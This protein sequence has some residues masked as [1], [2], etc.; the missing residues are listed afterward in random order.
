MIGKISQ[1]K[2]FR[3]A[4]DYILKKDAEILGGSMAGRS[5]R[6]LATEF[7]ITRKLREDIGAPCY[8][9][10][11][12]LPAGERLSS[13]EWE[14]VAAK[15]LTR[16]GLDPQSHQHVIVRHRD[17]NFDHA[18]IVVSRIALD[19]N[20]WKPYQ[21]RFKSKNICR[22][23]EKE[24]NL[25]VVSN[26]KKNFRAQTTQKERRMAQ[27]TGRTPEKVQVQEILST[28]LSKEN[29]ISYKN[30]IKALEQHSVIAVPNVA[31]TGK[32]SGFSFQYAGR[33]LTGSQ[34]GYSW[35]HLQP[36]LLPP[37][38]EEV[39]WLQ[40]RKTLL[41]QGTP[42]DA[43][44]SLRNACWE[45]GARGVNF[46]TAL[47][48]QGWVLEN[49]TLKK[50]E[51]RYPLSAFVDPET[52]QKAL[53]TLAAVSREK[54][55]AAAER[56]REITRGR[57]FQPR[58]SF[59]R[60]MGSEDLLLTM[61]LFPQVA[62]FLIA[63]TAVAEIARSVRQ[64]VAEQALRA[65]MQAAWR[66]ANTEVRAEIKKMQEGIRYGRDY[67]SDKTDIRKPFADGR[68]VGGADRSGHPDLCPMGS[69]ALRATGTGAG[70]PSE[71][72]SPRKP[73][74]VAAEDD[75]P[76]HGGGVSGGAGVSAGGADVAGGERLDVQTAPGTREIVTEAAE[77]MALAKELKAKA[78]EST[79]KGRSGRVDYITQQW[80]KQNDALRA[81]SYR[82]MLK[83]RGKNDKVSV[84]LGLLKDGQPVPEGKTLVTRDDDKRELAWTAEEVRGKI[85]SLLGWNR[86]GFDVYVTPIDDA[87][88]HILVDDLTEE[89]VRYIKEHYHPCEIHSSSKNNYQAIL[90]VPKKEISG[91]EQSAANVLIR[92]LNHLPAGCGGDTGIS[93]V[94]RNFRM[95]GF[96]NAKP[97][98][99]GFQ[100]DLIFSSPGA[101]CERAT[102]ELDA[103]RTQRQSQTQA[104]EKTRRV[105]AIETSGDFSI[106][107]PA[108]ETV[109]EKHFRRAWNRIHGLAKAKVE[110]G[111][112]GKIDSSTIDYRV[113]VEMLESGYSE[114][115]TAEAL[116]R[117]SPSLCDRHRD[118]LNYISLT[119]TAAADALEESLKG[120]SREEPVSISIGFGSDGR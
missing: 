98:R 91:E 95:T 113:C 33:N 4:L 110:E 10:S 82:I 68:A 12:S 114:E 111:I 23:L 112:W 44:R 69:G 66:T 107:R 35:K 63:L 79:M 74:P 109:A 39:A 20:V 64:G 24:H 83:G 11:L 41:H 46:T 104:Q 32:I 17:G 45:T 65:Q 70:A 58:R 116:Q 21:D 27:R 29:P 62:L 22:Q 78:E 2:S 76:L 102:A 88:H 25:T 7:G 6:E 42:A 56:C 34:V 13:Q 15:Y 49:G 103:I 105:K 100:S 36:L 30:F 60:E 67:D 118:P 71:P 87:F 43:A 84:N 90:R 120:Q 8:H 93:A 96:K 99:N 75:S 77:L 73:A 92:N 52:L 3:G 5:A 14:R 9:V 31:S 59:M 117:C 1:G 97:E 94:R 61:A 106:P 54:R 53:E 55:E 48:K 51:H 85:P 47:E 80:Y 16:M 101:V 28:I 86:R 50:G 38:P 26:E 81:P 72:G 57:Y 18:H 37:T 89:G 115:A 119:I 108:G 40:E 19:G